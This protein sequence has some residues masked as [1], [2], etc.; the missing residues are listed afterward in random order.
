LFERAIF[1]FEF[2]T[3]ACPAGTDLDC[4]SARR[5]IQMEHNT[6]TADAK[7]VMQQL[8]APASSPVRLTHRQAHEVLE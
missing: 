1:D 4:G 7:T 2:V 5:A 8:K 6:L 3:C